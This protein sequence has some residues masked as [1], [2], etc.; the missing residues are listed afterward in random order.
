M[1]KKLFAVA[2]GIALGAGYTLSAFAQAKPETLLEQRKGAMTLQGKYLY[3]IIPMA[4]GKIPYNAAIVARNAGFLDA[5]TQMPWDGFDPSTADLKNTRASPDI[6]KDQA[7]FRTAQENMR[8]EMGKFMATVKA[9]N[10][11]S[12]KEGI[13]ALNNTCNKCHDDFRIKR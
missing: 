10:E 1:Q 5:L 3:S 6:Y 4:S 8:A 13:V 2:L 7:K 12:I 9:G 11:A